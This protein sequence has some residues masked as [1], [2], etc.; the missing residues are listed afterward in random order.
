MIL[1]P[2]RVP[3]SKVHMFEG[4]I[5]EKESLD[6]EDLPLGACTHQPCARRI[7]LKCVHNM[8]SLLSTVL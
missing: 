8:Q 4:W 6:A 3:T 2:Q 7:Q 1:D 5:C